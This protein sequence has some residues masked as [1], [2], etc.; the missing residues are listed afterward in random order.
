MRK[1]K[2]EPIVSKPS[3]DIIALVNDAQHLLNYM[4]RDGAIQLESS[5]A[6]S[7][8]EAKFKIQNNQWQAQDEAAFLLNYDALSH[9]IHPV[10]IDSIDSIIPE[11]NKEKRPLTQAE[12]AVSWYR[13][14]ALISLVVLL[15]IQV[16]YLFGAN[17]NSNLKQAFKDK[18]SLTLQLD[19]LASNSLTNDYIEISQSL[20]TIEQQ[21]DA[22]YSLLK[23]WNRIWMLGFS[24]EPDL[25]AYHQLAFQ[26][27]AEQIQLSDPDLA[28]KQ[29]QLQLDKIHYLSQ[30]TF[31]EH[32][33]F[34]DSVLSVL[35][36]YILPLLYG[37]LG[38]FIFVLRD[39][40]REIKSLTFAYDDEIRYRLR[41]PLGSLA[42]M[43]IGWFF[44]PEDAGMVASLSPMALAFL[45]GYHVE[46]LFAFMDKAIANL[47]KQLEPQK[48]ASATKSVKAP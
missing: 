4:S 11:K 20:E 40:L 28:I 9:A 24:F 42:G 46:I 18:T 41:L 32:D 17:L 33:L 39:L 15:V 16:Y 2:S 48:N 21:F 31:F 5:I 26:L 23:S 10:T 25:P 30:L 44:K 12:S 8:V 35:Q 3:Q 34:S 7:I 37:L 6:N 29:Q 27:R 38:A 22:N 36:S 47:R 43:I 1:K 13:R 45:M 19:T 14:Y